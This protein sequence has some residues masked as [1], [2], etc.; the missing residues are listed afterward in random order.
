[1]GDAGCAKCDAKAACRKKKQ[2]GECYNCNDSC[3]ME[4]VGMSCS[5]SNVG[6]VAMPGLSYGYPQVRN[7]IDF[8]LQHFM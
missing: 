3:P 2:V 6:K 7:V 8:T 1:M 4:M 5:C